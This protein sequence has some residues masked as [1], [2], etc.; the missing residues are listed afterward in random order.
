MDKKF[1]ANI[2]FYS[3]GPTEN[4]FNDDDDEGVP[5]FSQEPTF[6]NE[7][8]TNRAGKVDALLMLNHHL[9]E[10]LELYK[11]VGDNYQEEFLQHLG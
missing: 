2:N 1:Y 7:T 10:E 3:A 8:V 11:S 4:E 6:L 9:E 5:D